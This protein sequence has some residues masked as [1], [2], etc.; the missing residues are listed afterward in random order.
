MHMPLTPRQAAAKTEVDYRTL[1]DGAKRGVL[2]CDW[3]PTSRDGKQPMFELAELLEDLAA[4]PCSY[5]G[6]SMPAPAGSGRCGR[7]RARGEASVELTCQ[8][9]GKT[10]TRPRSWLAEMEGRGHYCSNRCKGKGTMSAEALQERCKAGGARASEHQQRVDATLG[11]Q[12]YMTT[13]QMSVASQTSQSVLRSPEVQELAGAQLVTVDGS[14]RL[15]WPQDAP[16][17]SL[18]AR[19]G[20]RRELRASPPAIFGP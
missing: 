19:V 17:L 18:R 6:C 16:A 11:A 20:A 3:Q 13:A 5:P 10:F 4:C 7:H 15:A 9:C 2:R 1:V 12:G 8:H 14:Q